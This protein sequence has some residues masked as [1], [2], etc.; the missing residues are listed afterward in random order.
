[1]D[2]FAWITHGMAQIL[3]LLHG[4]TGSYGIAIILLTLLIR[5]ATYPLTLK[6][7]E[8]M[9][10]MRAIAPKVQEIQKKYKDRP[11]EYQKRVMQL[12]RENGVNPLGGCLP[13]LVQLPFLWALFAVLRNP[14]T[15]RVAERFLWLGNLAHAD[16]FYV[17][18]V[19]SAVT[20]YFQSTVMGTGNEPTAR[21]MLWIMPVFIGWISATLPAGLVLYWVVSNLF[22]IGQGLL[23]MRSVRGAGEGGAG[24]R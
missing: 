6:Q 11:E 7:T 18:P 13:L 1:M 9:L 15:F 22:S 3:D 5:L 4:L 24:G 14:E 12:Y 10:R 8:S 21:T 19:L 20:T 17:L 2:V 23:I 16:P